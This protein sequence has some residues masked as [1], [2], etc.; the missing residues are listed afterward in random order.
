MI[1]VAIATM[2]DLVAWLMETGWKEYNVLKYVFISTSFKGRAETK[3]YSTKRKIGNEK[4]FTSAAIYA[5]ITLS[6]N[7]SCC[8]FSHSSFTLDSMHVRVPVKVLRWAD[9]VICR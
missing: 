5:G 3:Y 4:V 6:N 1:S 2:K 9:S 8:S 7:C